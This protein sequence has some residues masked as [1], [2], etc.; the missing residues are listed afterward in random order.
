MSQVLWDIMVVSHGYLIR[1]S[2]RYLNLGERQN[3]ERSFSLSGFQL[4][5]LHVF[6]H[7]TGTV[8]QEAHSIGVLVLRLDL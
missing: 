4:V 1:P 5:D 6:L 7:L 8:T 3:P 2:G